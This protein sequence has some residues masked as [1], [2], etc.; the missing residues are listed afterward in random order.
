MKRMLCMLLLLCLLCTPFLFACQQEP[1]AADPAGS[2]GAETGDEDDPYLP[3]KD[4]GGYQWRVLTVNGG[5]S[6]FELTPEDVKND[7]MLDYLYRRDRFIMDRFNIDITALEAV[8]H[9]CIATFVMQN[10]LSGDDLFDIGL[11]YTPENAAQLI[12]NNLTYDMTTLPNVNLGNP[13]YNQQANEEYSIMG[14]QYFAVSDYPFGGGAFSLMLFNKNMMAEI[15]L[16]L[17]Y[18]TI[19]DG[20]W[21]IE[22]MQEYSRQA[23]I[24]VDNSGSASIGDRFG[25]STHTYGPAYFYISMGGVPTVRDENGAVVPVLDGERVDQIYSKIYNFVNQPSNFVNVENDEIEMGT[26]WFFDGQSLFHYFLRSASDLLS[27]ETF[28]YGLAIEPKFD[29]DQEEY[30]VPGAGGVV[31][32][33]KYISDPET[34]GYLLEAFSQATMIMVKPKYGEEYRRLRILRDPESV[35]VY[36]LCQQSLVYDILKNCDPSNMLSSC[37]WFRT[38]LNSG[39]TSVATMAARYKEAVEASFRD[40]YYPKD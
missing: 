19:L 28:D 33:S 26:K 5:G 29:I 2:S 9:Y 11:L 15:G 24:D 8:E 21:T 31:M 12:S 6:Q 16:E 10:M 36:D 23:W 18:Q 40:F 20:E 35:E 37:N 14:R 38:A 1:A 3:A 13:W 25:F 39:Y 4:M 22:L 17:P 27:I 7:S 32:I 34:T 30:R